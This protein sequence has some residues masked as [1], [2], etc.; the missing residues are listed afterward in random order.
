MN[1]RTVCILTV[2]AAVMACFSVGAFAQSN[3]PSYSLVT[4]I[5]APGGLAGYDINWVDESHSRYYLADRTGTRA[6]AA[7]T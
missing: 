7:L 5:K 6:R 2:A 1:K 4:T 3:A